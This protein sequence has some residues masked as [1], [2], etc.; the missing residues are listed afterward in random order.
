[1][2]E[3]KDLLKLKLKKLRLLELK[4]E[5][6]SMLPHLY[7]R[8]RY[9]WQ[10]EYLETTNPIQLV[11]AANQIGKSTI[12]IEKRVDIATNPQ[13]W[14]HLWPAA[15]AI[16][17]SIKPYSWYLY[18]NQDTTLTEFHEKWVPDILPNGKMK[19]HPVFG[20]KEMIQNKVLK[21]IRFNT[22]YTIYFKTYSQNVQDLQSGTVYAID[23]DEE[24]PA[25]K[26]PELQARLFAT[27]GSFSMV[28]TATSGQELWRRAIEEKGDR[29]AFPNAFKRQI[30][31]YDCL[32]YEDGSST[33]WTSERIRQIEASCGTEAERKRRVH[34]RFVRSEGL[35]YEGFDRR[36]NYVPA[37][38]GKNGKPFYGC[39]KGW[40]VYSAVD[41][42]SGGASGHP[43]AYSFVSV[44]PDF[45]KIRVFR[46]RRLDGIKTTA[47]D[48]YKYYVQDRGR[49]DVDVQSYDWASADFAN[50]AVSHGDAFTKALKGHEAGEM[51]LNTAFK[52]GILKIYHGEEMEKLVIELENDGKNTPKNKKKDDLIDTLRYIIMSIPVDWSTIAEELMSNGNVEEKIKGDENVREARPRDFWETENDKEEN[53]E[54]IEQEFKFW[55]DLY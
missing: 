23:A 24:L 11:C 46:A 41:I 8:K 15:Y 4:H 7:A 10:R 12:Q 32:K 28:F 14:R 22:G 52:A 21:Y 33:R 13:R 51:A 25:E 42:G 17:P 43:S 40:S 30:S 18:P 38:K 49:L 5:S 9:P 31:M 6:E 3:D 27:D 29:E 2:V 44:S 53:S 26:F 37:P 19:E 48:T 47:G 55:N 36:K 39:P 16:N 54:S 45:K 50:I 20:W 35:T 1:M 34:G